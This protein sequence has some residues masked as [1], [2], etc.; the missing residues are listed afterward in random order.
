MFDADD[1]F[2]G[3]LTGG[4]SAGGIVK[5]KGFNTKAG[6]S[7]TLQ[8][9]AF[10]VSWSSPNAQLYIDNTNLG[11]IASSSDYRIKQNIS[12]ITTE[13]IDRIKLLRPVQYEFGNYGELFT[14]DGVVREGFIAHEVASVISS[15][16]EGTKDDPDCIQSLRLDAILNVTVKALQEAVTKI[17]TLETS[18]AA[19]E[20]RVTTLEAP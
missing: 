18:V 3:E 1:F 17:E 11:T 12:T 10:N 14:P 20:A 5:A 15:G 4:N 19:L 8:S 7:G 9:N 6:H 13:C 2:V 16:V